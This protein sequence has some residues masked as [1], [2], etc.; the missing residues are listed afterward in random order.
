MQRS[1]REGTTCSEHGSRGSSPQHSSRGRSLDLDLR[2]APCYHA[3]IMRLLPYS[4]RR[5]LTLQHPTHAPSSPPVSCFQP[6]PRSHPHRSVKHLRRNR[7]F[8]PALPP[9]QPSFIPHPLLTLPALSH[10]ASLLD[11]SFKSGAVYLEVKLAELQSRHKHHGPEI[12][13]TGAAG[14]DAHLFGVCWQLLGELSRMK[15]PFCQALSTIYLELDKSIHSSYVAA[16][17]SSISSTF[18]LVRLASKTSR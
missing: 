13:C 1:A 12:S 11:H 8:K 4:M 9:A 16:K 15:T 3:A 18:Q 7:G 14:A 2:N 5:G 10:N 6:R 17:S